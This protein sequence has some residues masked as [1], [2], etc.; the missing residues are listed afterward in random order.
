MYVYVRVCIF[1][2]ILFCLFFL[3]FFLFLVEKD[4]IPVI[5]TSLY[6]CVRNFRIKNSTLLSIFHLLAKNLK[7]FC[8][9]FR[10]A[11]L[12]E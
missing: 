9:F 2:R 7:T 8:V 11:R 5:I 12:H 4:V 3:F 6:T 1:C 10:Q